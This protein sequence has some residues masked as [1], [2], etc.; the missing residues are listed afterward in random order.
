MYS[1]VQGQEGKAGAQT[2][3]DGG[4]LDQGG[5]SGDDEKWT[6]SEVKPIRPSDW[7]WNMKRRRRKEGPLVSGKSFCFLLFK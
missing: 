7:M 5:P 4:G 6:D 3:D 1:G 2:R